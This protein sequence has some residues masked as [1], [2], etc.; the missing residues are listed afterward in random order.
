MKKI[1]T[2]LACTSL[3]AAC[4]TEPAPLP[5][6]RLDYGSLGKISLNVQDVGVIDRS[7][8]YVTRGTNMS[9]A[10]QPTLTDALN[11]WVQDRLQ[12]TGNAGHATF[13]IKQASLVE[14]PLRMATGVDSWFTRQQATKYLGHIEVQLDAQSPVNNAVGSASAQATYAITLPEDPTPNEKNA[15]YRQL[16][17]GLMKDLNQRLDG[18]IRQ[19]MPWFL[20]TGGSVG[21]GSALQSQ[22]APYL[23][24]QAP[25]SQQ[26]PSDEPEVLPSASLGP[27]KPLRLR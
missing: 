6:M 9:R 15:A 14:Q 2:L 22:A 27:A 13:I 12:A 18:A 10:F 17:D 7:Q 1:L 16:L 23:A 5:P 25:S 4:S 11:R 26:S 24:P 21:Y 19:H 8:G 3:L 20:T